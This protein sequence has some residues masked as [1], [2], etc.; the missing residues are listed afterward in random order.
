M[1]K[2][3]NKKLYNLENEIVVKLQTSLVIKVSD[4][5]IHPDFMS[6]ERI[7]QL[8]IKEVNDRLREPGGIEPVAF[9]VDILDGSAKSVLK[10]LDQVDLDSD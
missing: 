2:K 4:L 8:V 7:K 5:D 9:T 1:P 3:P 10:P 6:V